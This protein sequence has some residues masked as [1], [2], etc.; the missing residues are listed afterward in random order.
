MSTFQA[1]ILNSSTSISAT[2]VAEKERERRRLALQQALAPYLSA[3]QMAHTVR[4]CEEE[5][6]EKMSISAAELCQRLFE[7]MPQIQL[8]KDARLRLLR[9]MRQPSYTW[10]A[11]AVRLTPKRSEP[12]AFPEPP[13][14][15]KPKQAAEP[16][17]LT[18][19]AAFSEPIALSSPEDSTSPELLLI[20]ETPPTM[21]SPEDSVSPEIIVLRY[22]NFGKDILG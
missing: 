3:D 1:P 20:A 11:D 6:S 19:P 5:F 8:D 21:P 7:T 18:E 17:P 15:S 10:I 4:L 14:V 22:A 12:L 2:S 16:I 13:E 9:A